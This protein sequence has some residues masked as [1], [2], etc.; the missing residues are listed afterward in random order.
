MRTSRPWFW[1]YFLIGKEHEAIFL[2][3]HR[4]FWKSKLLW[5]S[6]E[7]CSKWW[8]YESLR[9]LSCVQTSPQP[10]TQG[11][12]FRSLDFARNFVT[13]P[14]GILRERATHSVTSLIFRSKSIEREEKAW[15]LGWR[16]LFP[17]LHR[18]RETCLQAHIYKTKTIPFQCPVKF[19]LY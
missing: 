6:L 11:F 18:K 4:S 5:L 1:Y 12:S 10:S 16:L 15:V 7:N 9:L 14:N 2:T 19:Y 8:I 17:L 13:S 3:N